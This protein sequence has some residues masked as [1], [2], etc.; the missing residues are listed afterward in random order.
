VDIVAIEYLIEALGEVTVE[1]Y[2]ETVTMSNF[3]EIVYDIR[4]AS[5]SD[6]STEHKRFLAALYA[7]VIADWQGADSETKS[8]ID[9]ALLKAVQE[10]HLMFYMVDDVVQTAVLQLDWAS[11]PDVSATSDYLMVADAN[12]GNKSSS[13]V[14]R[15]ITY[16]VSLNADDSAN[17]HLTVFYNFSAAQ[18][19]QDPAVSPEHYG[20][21]LD[22][23]SILQIFTPP[24]AVAVSPDPAN[25]IIVAA[26]DDLNIFV[27][28]LTVLYNNTNRVELDY[29]M[30]Q[31]VDTLGDLKRYTL[32][33]EKQPGVRQ[34]IVT[35][36]ITLPPGASFVSATPEPDATYELGREVLEF[37]LA[38]R[39][40]QEI[41][42]IYGD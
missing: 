24:D 18:A 28:Q 17:S 6:A 40:D 36:S 30:P 14:E 5:S 8:Q 31:I 4:A 32:R 9:R 13:S 34:D 12:L 3:R 19:E 11:K 41:E 21:Q 7:Q 35:I 2:N 39:K 33:F 1:E 42:I 38:L 10:K 26:T 29:T 25:E 23:H 16:D 22:Y 20:N 15:Q 27:T 37:T